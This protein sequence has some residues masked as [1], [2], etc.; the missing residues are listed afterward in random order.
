MAEMIKTRF[1]IFPKMLIAMAL[2]AVVPL[3]VTWYIN[4]QT[5][6]NRTFRE[7]KRSCQASD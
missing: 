6:S 5:T 7:S 2:I 3:A 4:L 1:G